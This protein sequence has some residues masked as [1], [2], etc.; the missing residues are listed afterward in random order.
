MI[1]SKT[2][3]YG[4]CNLGSNPRTARHYFFVGASKALFRMSKPPV[5]RKVDMIHRNSDQQL[6]GVKA[7][8]SQLTPRPLLIEF[9]LTY[10][11]GAN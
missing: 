6:K 2:L 4:R 10:P 8:M 3:A 7:H 9:A 1:Q 11:S 5:S